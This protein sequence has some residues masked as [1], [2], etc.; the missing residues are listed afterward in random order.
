MQFIVKQ[1]APF[2]FDA[3]AFTDF[4]NTLKFQPDLTLYGPTFDHSIK[5]PTPNGIEVAKDN[6]I[7]ILEGNYVLLNEGEW[8]NCNK[9]LDKRLWVDVNEETAKARLIMRHVK[10]GICKNE[11]E[12]LIRVNDNDLLNGKYA[13]SR[14]LNDTLIINSID[15]TNFGI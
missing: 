2:T 4:V 6:R 12:A 1:G 15:D 9:H 7:I 11:E 13:R 10:S 5:D 8:L 14:L 3:K